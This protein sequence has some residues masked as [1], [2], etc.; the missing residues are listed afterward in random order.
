[1]EKLGIGTNTSLEMLGKKAWSAGEPAGGSWLSP[2]LAAP[3][4]P[5]RQ[6][7]VDN[8]P[9]KSEKSAPNEAPWRA[10]I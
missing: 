7:V 8:P 2:R 5:P 4:E 10:E 1:L 6:L 3:R 9:N